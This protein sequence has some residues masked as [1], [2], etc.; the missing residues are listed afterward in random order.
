MHF[1][2]GIFETVLVALADYGQL[3]SYWLHQLV[4]YLCWKRNV[5][6]KKSWDQEWIHNI[7]HAP[8]L[9]NDSSFCICSVH[10]TEALVLFDIDSNN[11]HPSALTPKQNSNKQLSYFLG[12]AVFEGLQFFYFTPCLKQGHDC[13]LN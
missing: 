12:F 6:I 5:S 13:F 9:P 11:V 1:K 7:Y 3:Y 4:K 8:H 2:S 10:F